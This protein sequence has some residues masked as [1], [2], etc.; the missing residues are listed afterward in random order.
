MGN[1]KLFIKYELF[2]WVFGVILVI[3][4][5]LFIRSGPSAV[6]ALIALSASILINDYIIGVHDRLYAHY[7]DSKEII[8]YLLNKSS[9]CAEVCALET[10]IMMPM[11]SGRVNRLL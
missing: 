2:P 10:I 9:N 5:I 8:S 4:N 3:A 11:T 1:I 6:G 7:G